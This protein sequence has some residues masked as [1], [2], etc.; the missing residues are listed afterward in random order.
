MKRK[1]WL[2][3]TAVLCTA[4][5]LSATSIPSATFAADSYADIEKSA[6]AKIA[7]EFAASYATSLEQS[8][9]LV[10]GIKGD[11]TVNIEDSGRSLLGFVAPFDV[12]W[13]NNA[14]VT[15][16]SSFK[17]NKEGGSM[18]LLVND[19]QVCTLDFYFDPDTEDMYMKVN[20]KE[21][22]DD[23]TLE[24][25]TEGLSDSVK[26]LNNMTEA[27]PEASVVES[28]LNKYGTILI[29]NVKSTDGT[30]DTLTA[31][32]VSQ[33]CTV[34]EGTLDS[35]AAIRTLTAVLE[36]S[37]SDKEIEAILEKW[38][39][40]LPDSQDLN[41]QFQEAV[42]S[43]LNAL[44]EDSSDEASQDGYFSSK[45]WVGEDGEII[46]RSLT[47]HDA[48]GDTPVFT[49]QMPKSDSSYGYLL[50]IYAEDEVYAL[51]GNGTIEN[52][53]LNGSYQFSMND[54]PAAN[55]EVKDYDTAE[56]KKGNINGSYSISF[57]A[58]ESDDSSDVSPLTNFSLDADIASTAESGSIKLGIVSAGAT[59]GSVS[60]V[61]GK[62]DGVDI[63][64]LASLKD[65]CDVS[66]DD[67]MT[68]YVSSMDFTK[69][70]DNLTAAGVPD[71]VI[72][73]IL[74]GGSSDTDT[75]IDDE[76]IN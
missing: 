21:T 75:E 44:K 50:E 1:K 55:I 63:P 76:S 28:L 62:G 66:N 47:M 73:Y 18:A 52:D 11:I 8:Q 65:V 46:G 59:L 40:V 74:S 48:S 49:W 38:S 70:M 9:D 53:I 19:S 25:S 34:Y 31:G 17:D 15:I 2:Q 64:D 16:N 32:D 12:S 54:E 39:A 4:M 56:A 42:D 6:L 37:K 61:S 23:E 20:L 14:S 45:T 5:V 60:F 43:G 33:D 41:A 27:M 29:D 58:D 35:E 26:L 71:E 10:S 72:T 51:S 68:D 67:D 36:T 30:S 3:K 69:L 22:E 13:L 57:V 7:S 24:A